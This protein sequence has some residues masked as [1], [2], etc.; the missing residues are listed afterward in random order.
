MATSLNAMV[1]FFEKNEL[2]KSQYGGFRNR[3][4]NQPSILAGGIPT[5]LKN[6]SQLGWLFPVYGEIIINMFQ[7]NNQYRLITMAG[8][9]CNLPILNHMS[10]SMGRIIPWLWKIKAMFETTN[11]MLT[12]GS[13]GNPHLGVRGGSAFGD[14]SMAAAVGHGGH[15]SPR[16][17]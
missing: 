7:T 15:G 17:S 14:V 2:A 8:W 9:W 12:W 6:T 16:C 11:Q 4:Q 10:S 13:H 3:P 1:D 5:P